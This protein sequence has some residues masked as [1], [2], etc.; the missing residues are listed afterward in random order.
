MPYYKTGT[1]SLTNGDPIVTAENGANWTTAQVRPGDAFIGPNNTIHEILEILSPTQL[2]LA[3]PFVGAGGASQTYAILPS[4]APIRDLY[5][6][7]N[8]LVVEYRGFVDTVGQGM[9]ASGSLALPGIRFV[10]D[11]DTG[12]ARTGNNELSLVTGGVV[13]AKAKPSVFEV[14]ALAVGIGVPD[15]PM[16]VAKPGNSATTTAITLDNPGFGDGVSTR[17]AFKS[18]GQVYGAIVGGFRG[19]GGL[20]FETYGVENAR[21]ISG[22]FLVGTTSGTGHTFA[23]PG[24]A[25]GTE[26][27]RITNNGAFSGIFYASGGSS[28]NGAATVF[29]LSQNTQTG[30]SIN[31]SGTINASG[32]DYAEYV[33]KSDGCGTIAKGDVCGIDREGKLTKSWADAVS[34]V[35][36]STDPNLVGGDGWG[37]ELGPRPEAPAPLDPQPGEPV[38]PDPFVKRRPEQ[39]ETES[40]GEFAVRVYQWEEERDAATAAL[41]RYAAAMRAYPAALAEWMA[42]ERVHVAGKADYETALAEWETAFEAERVKVDRIAFCGIVPVN[43]SADILAECEAAL[44]DGERVYLVAIA[45]GGGI[46]VTAV[47]KNAMT[48][49]DHLDRLGPVWRIEDGRPIIDVQHG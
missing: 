24:A 32:A 28:P 7:V 46:A 23:I 16:H 6:A 5:S 3:R 41:D 19:T 15:S 36:K 2:S 44:V 10:E 31:A 22:K 17:L 38:A 20:F 14:P 30:R 35:V 49:A 4:Q 33:R 27:F 29:S 11:Q 39:F 12:I 18:A 21:L 25:Q 43:V 13:R 42:A 47:R 45:N 8:S 26:M 40:E 34:F 1:V 37:R 48:L 9:F